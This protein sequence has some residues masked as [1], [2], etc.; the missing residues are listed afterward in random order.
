MSESNHDAILHEGLN[1]PSPIHRVIAL[2]WH[3]GPTGGVLQLGEAGPVFRFQ[4]FDQR[5]GVGPDDMDLRVYGLYPL[6]NDALNR[7][8]DSLASYHSPHWPVWWPIWQFPSDEIR[9]SVDSRIDG[10]L[11]QSGPL[12][13]VVVGDMGQ[14]AIRALPVQIAKAS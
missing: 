3:D 7:I 5:I 4:M 1:D 13:W 2:D 14:T 11:Q 10:I 8:T 12:T 9:R 6:P